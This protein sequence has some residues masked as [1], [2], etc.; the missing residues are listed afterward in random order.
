MILPVW[1]NVTAADVTRYS[2]SLAAK[3]ARN[4]TDNT[5]EEIAAEVAEVARREA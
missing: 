4:T 3:L 1:H 5:V 2:P